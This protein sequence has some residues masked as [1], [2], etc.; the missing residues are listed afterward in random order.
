MGSNLL[1]GHESLL[2][3]DVEIKSSRAASL[4]F[5]RFDICG[6]RWNRPF[7]WQIDTWFPRFQN[8]P[9][10]WSRKSDRMTICVWPCSVS[11]SSNS[12]QCDEMRLSTRPGT[13]VL[14]CSRDFLLSCEVACNSSIAVVCGAWKSTL[15]HMQNIR[16]GT[17][18]VLNSRTRLATSTLCACFHVVISLV[19]FM[20]I[21]TSFAVSP[22]HLDEQGFSGKTFL[23][24]CTFF[25]CGLVE[26]I[27]CQEILQNRFKLSRDQ[28]LGEGATAFC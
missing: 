19:L 11:L 8:F 24:F 22:G 2:S 27:C 25:F 12:R 13:V 21:K 6:K 3:P 9:W 10:F 20:R 1:Q 28:V 23:R 17:H 7:F 4:I 26:P 14:W 15:F 16:W 5:F 18:Q